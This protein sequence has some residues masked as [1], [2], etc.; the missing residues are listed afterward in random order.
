MMPHCDLCGKPT[1]MPFHCQYCGGN[2][3]DEHRLPPNHDC[4]GIAQ[5]KKKPLPSVGISYG[6]GGTITTTG[7]GYG[8][9]AR[10]GKAAKREAGIPW[11]KIMIV[12][13]AIILLLLAFFAAK[14][15]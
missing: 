8:P 4:A 2:F 13:I 7:S 3:C 15:L 6:K 11:L 5:W 12:L 1:T 10:R 14:G 9:E